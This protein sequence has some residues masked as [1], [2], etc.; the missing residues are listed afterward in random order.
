MLADA[1]NPDCVL[2]AIESEGRKVD[3]KE[4]ILRVMTEKLCGRQEI[5]PK[6]EILDAVLE[7]ERERST[8]I[9]RGLAVPHCRTNAVENIHIS[10][11]ILRDGI[12]WGS[13]D[14]GP[15]HFIFLVIGPINKPEEYLK[16]LSQISRLMKSDTVR[17]RLFEARTPEEV[18][19]IL[20][21][22]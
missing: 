9:E 7:R 8:G 13:L 20:R 18:I 4:D 5:G 16:L 12:E 3:D 2:F 22:D 11:A 14:G 6:D 10:I 1:I 17:E 15:T 19:D 21:Q